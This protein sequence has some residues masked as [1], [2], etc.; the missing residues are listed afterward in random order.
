MENDG[1]NNYK[2]PHMD[3]EKLARVGQLPTSISIDP[4]FIQRVQALVNDK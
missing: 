1:G 3:K 2:I 4:D